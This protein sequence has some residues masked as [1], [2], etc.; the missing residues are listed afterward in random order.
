MADAST[1]VNLVR[2]ILFLIVATAVT[3]LFVASAGRATR[4]ASPTRSTRSPPSPPTRWR[5][6]TARCSR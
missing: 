5:P 2:Q 1:R 6:G 3:V 4:I